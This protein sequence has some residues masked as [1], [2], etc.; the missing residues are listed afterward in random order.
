MEIRYC[1]ELE[2]STNRY[3][4]REDGR[5]FIENK[6]SGDIREKS[7]S[8]NSDGYYRVKS[9]GKCFLVHRIVAQMFIPNPLNKPQVNHLN[10]IKVDNRVENLEW[11]TTE[12]NTRHYLT[13]LIKETDMS[14]VVICKVRKQIIDKSTTGTFLIKRGYKPQV[15]QTSLKG[16]YTNS[17]Y[18]VVRRKELKSNSVDELLRSRMTKLH[19]AGRRKYTEEDVDKILAEFKLSGEGIAEFSRKRSMCHKVIRSMIEGNYF[20]DKP[21]LR[22]LRRTSNAYYVGIWRVDEYY[23]TLYEGHIECAKNLI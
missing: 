1:E 23:N 17:S 15:I 13:E 16:G 19:K 8:E 14:P 10:G 21:Y 20:E 9:A 12:E 18:I 3:L 11:V 5:I 4:V 22:K 6:I 2:N 7:V